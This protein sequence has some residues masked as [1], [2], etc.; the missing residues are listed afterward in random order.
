[1]RAC[2]AVF[3]P[4]LNLVSSRLVPACRRR[5]DPG[6]ARE[7]SMSGE[8]KTHEACSVREDP[9]MLFVGFLILLLD[10]LSKYL[11]CGYL[12]SHGSQPVIPGIFHL[13]LVRNTGAAFGIL[14]GG[15][16]FFIAVSVLFIGIILLLECRHRKACAFFGLDPKDALVRLAFGMILGGACGNLVDRIRFSYVVDF[17]D[18]RVWPVFNIAD[19]AITVGG[20][21]IVLG[22]LRKGRGGPHVSRPA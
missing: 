2:L 17:L 21:L 9:V 19:S 8:G 18:L 12:A 15:T 3:I 11:A 13:T 20:C 6:L 16:Y 22:M 5:E 10:Q 7:G 1:M 4:L 14:K